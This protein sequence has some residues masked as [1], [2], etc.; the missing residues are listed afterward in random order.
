MTPRFQSWIDDVPFPETGN[1]ER[2]LHLGGLRA[3]TSLAWG[4]LEVPSILGYL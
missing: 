4:R 2:G 3:C 1:T